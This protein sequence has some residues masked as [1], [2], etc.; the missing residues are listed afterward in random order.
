LNRLNKQTNKQTNKLGSVTDAPVLSS[1]MFLRFYVFL[2]LFWHLTLR[3][4]RS[5]GAESLRTRD[6]R[7][8]NFLRLGVLGMAFLCCDLNNASRGALFFRGL[9]PQ[10]N[11]Q[12]KPLDPSNRVQRH[13]VIQLFISFNPIPSPPQRP[14]AD[15]GLGLWG[16]ACAK[17]LLPPPFHGMASFLGCDPM[18]SE[19]KF[20]LFIE[21]L[22]FSKD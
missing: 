14:G 18:E 16:C 4:Y 10:T 11:K 17:I 19:N 7:C 20:N 12:T 9:R 5:T 2:V 13:S 3:L 22:F 21:T 15:Q 1:F 6:E 8:S